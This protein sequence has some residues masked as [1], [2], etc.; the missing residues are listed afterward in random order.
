MVWAFVLPGA[1][2]ASWA[3]GVVSDVHG[4]P[5]RCVFTPLGCPLALGDSAGSWSSV[6]FLSVSE[7]SSVLCPGSE[8][9]FSARPSLRK[10]V[11]GTPRSG[12]GALDLQRFSLVLRISTCLLALRVCFCM[13]AT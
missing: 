5:S 7:E 3:C 8:V 11:R 13:L 4:P 6:A 2:W 1:A 12:S 9:L 10:H